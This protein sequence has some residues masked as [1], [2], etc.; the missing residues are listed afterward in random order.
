M[1][2]RDPLDG[3]SS[4]LNPVG[5]ALSGFAKLLGR[6]AARELLE[7]CRTDA[8]GATTAASTITPSTDAV[9]ITTERKEPKE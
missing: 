7:I 8:R 5:G 3:N 6:A 4:I 2:S 1:I 9:H